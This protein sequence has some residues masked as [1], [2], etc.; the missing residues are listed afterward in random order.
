MEKID[1]QSVEFRSN[2]AFNFQTASAKLFDSVSLMAN[3][4]T[5]PD[6]STAAAFPQYLA[7]EVVAD[8]VALQW[9]GLYARRWRLPR[10]VDHFLVPATP[11]PHISCNLRGMAEFRE[12]DVGGTWITRQ[13]HGGDLFVTRSRT[14]YEVDFRSPPGE[15]LDNLSIHIAVEPFLGALEA[16][17]PGKADHVQ[18]VDYFGRDEI[19]WPICLTCAELLAARVP[20][21]SPL[22][23][24]L[25]Q[26]FAAHLVEKYTDAAAKTLAYRGGL[27]IRQLRKVEDY[28]TGHLAEAISIEQLAELVEL[29]SSHFAHV[30][31]ESTGMTPLQFVTRQRV[32][33][34]QQLIRETSRSLIDIGLEVGYTSPS[35]FAQVFRRVVGVTP[36]QFRS[37][38]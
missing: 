29:S 37:S 5:T 27:P 23:A 18:V 14:P 34:A 25:T 22:I 3:K 16:R 10:V 32:T 31:K 12:R 30:F 15:E 6:R 36:N 13:I 21:K 4:M 11:E 1:R 33:R 38:L 24:A 26:L 8:S 19:L 17:Y 20:G 7:G 35:H 2:K 28:V 9:P